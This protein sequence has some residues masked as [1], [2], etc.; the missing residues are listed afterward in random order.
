[1]LELS[2]PSLRTR[3][4]GSH[5]FAKVCRSLALNHKLSFASKSR[6]ETKMSAL[7]VFFGTMRLFWRRLGLVF[8]KSVFL[9]GVFS[10]TE[11]SPTFTVGS[12]FF[13][14]AISLWMV[15]FSYNLCSFVQLIFWVSG[16][17][18]FDSR[19]KP[20]NFHASKSRCET[21]GFLSF[22]FFCF[23]RHYATFFRKFSD[24]IKG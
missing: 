20:Q 6:G 18:G 7:W 22:N 12:F 5:S 8:T 9:V 21:K 16:D 11:K 10:L 15:F 24:S 19:T 14:P 17:R 1:M 3:L 4:V 13:Q 2:G 23:F